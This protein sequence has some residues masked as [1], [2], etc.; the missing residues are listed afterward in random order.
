MLFVRVFVSFF[1]L[2]LS[3]SLS[4]SL[5]LS[6]CVCVCQ[7]DYSQSNHPISLK[8]DIMIGPTDG[9]NQ[10]TFGGDPAPD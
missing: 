7:Q 8:L 5:P 1:F 9:K 3:L 4:L 10:L 2:S 6:V